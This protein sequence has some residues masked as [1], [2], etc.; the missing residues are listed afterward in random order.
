M[1]EIPTSKRKHADGKRGGEKGWSKKV[2]KRRNEES[3][4][5]E[6]DHERSP[7]SHPEGSCCEEEDLCAEVAGDDGGKK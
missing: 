5:R 1:K 6:I 7:G 3:Q 2:K 4:T